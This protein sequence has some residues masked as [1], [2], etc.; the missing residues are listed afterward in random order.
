VLVS[1]PITI[2]LYLPAGGR[3]WLG[4]LARFAERRSADV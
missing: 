3:V 4:G 1:S 2:V